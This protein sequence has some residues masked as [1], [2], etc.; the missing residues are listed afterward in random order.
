M[1][2]GATVKHNKFSAYPLNWLARFYAH[3]PKRLS[4]VIAVIAGALGV[5]AKDC[6]DYTRFLVSGKLAAV[7]F[8]MAGLLAVKAFAVLSLLVRGFNWAILR[9]TFLASS[10][11]WCFSATFPG[12]PARRSIVTHFLADAAGYIKA[13]R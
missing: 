6:C 2:I 13:N 11:A 8:H 9:P 10:L 1:F 3:T 4:T 12:K 7:S 5:G